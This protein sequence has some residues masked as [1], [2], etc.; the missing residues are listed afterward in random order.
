MAWSPRLLSLLGRPP[1]AIAVGS[2]LLHGVGVGCFTVGGQVFL[3]S[4]APTRQRASAQGLFL[5]L[6]SRPGSLLGNLMAGELAGTHLDNDV[7]VFLIP[8]VLDG[9]MLI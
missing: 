3:D 5:V 1:L 6:T 2:G 7:L 4:R 9:A 8:C